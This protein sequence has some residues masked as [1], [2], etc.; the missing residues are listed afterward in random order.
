[1]RLTRSSNSWRGSG[2]LSCMTARR[3][4]MWLLGDARLSLAAEAPQQFNVIV[5]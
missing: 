1:M 3:R 2:L 4:P 5:I